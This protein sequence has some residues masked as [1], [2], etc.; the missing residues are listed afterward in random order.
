MA[1]GPVLPPFEHQPRAYNGPTMSDVLSQRRAFLAPHM[2]H[3]YE[4]P[5]MI[6]EGAMQYVY[7]E[8]GRRYLDAFGGI[9]TVSVGHC[10][11]KVT[12]AAKQQLD[13]LQH[14]S[15]LYLH[16]VVGAY[17]EA[18]V[19]KFPEP[20]KVVYFVNSGSEAND[21]AITMARL[22]TGNFD[23]IGLRNGFHGT[24]PLSG[25]LIANHNWRYNTP[26]GFGIHH[27]GA[28]YAYRG[29][30][31]QDASE[32]GRNYAEAIRST[33]EASTSG[34]IAALFAESIQ[35][36]GGV[37]VPPKD[38][39]SAAAAIARAAGGLYIA[40]EVQSGFARTGTGYW[41]FERDGVVPDIVTMA[42]GIGNG[43]PM[44]ALVTSREIAE[45][46]TQRSTFNTFGGNPVSCTIGKAVLDA[47]DEDGLQEN[48][49][50]VGRHL[51]GR[52]DALA[53]KHDIIGEV[54]GAGLMLGIELVT[55]RVAKMPA[56]AETSRIH[57]TLR[58]L[59]ALVGKAGF[60]G[61]VIR[62][63]PPLCMTTADADFL[64]DALDIGFA[65]I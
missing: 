44:A 52:L 16:P 7:D 30:W 53:A 58:E 31:A 3:Y 4:N 8:T 2:R 17:A 51:R 41:G 13:T 37:I 11:P 12:G 22:F 15:T 28:P 56:A 59:G 61:N 14:A 42:K 36:V 40:D 33:I 50:R 5:L 35:G 49:E 65:A 1:A 29:P 57:E 45:V 46:L 60:A 24:S 18:L 21:L 23:V 32:A 10:H 39:L 26:S 6:V 20:L 63:T 62:I 19:A 48:A 54:R 9:V 64:A 38:F 43:T 47:I 34:R 27:A 25:S 55:D